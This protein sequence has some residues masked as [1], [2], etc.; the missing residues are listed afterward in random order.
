MGKSDDS[1]STI[2]AIHAQAENI[3]TII[4]ALNPSLGPASLTDIISRGTPALLPHPS[5]SLPYFHS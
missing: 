2:P 1:V 4:N 5:P 3:V